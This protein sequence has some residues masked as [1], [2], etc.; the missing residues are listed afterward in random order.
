MAS[1]K[2]ATAASVCSFVTTAKVE[3]FA[4]GKVGP[5]RGGIDRR[6]RRLPA[7]AHRA[8][9]PRRPSGADIVTLIRNGGKT[10]EEGVP[11]ERA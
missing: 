4:I 7:E 3:T 9:I 6:T 1:C 2:S 11:I 10:P 8:A 5:L